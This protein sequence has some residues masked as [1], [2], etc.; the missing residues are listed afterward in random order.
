MSGPSERVKQQLSR[1]LAKEL[2]VV[3]STGVAPREQIEAHLAEHLEHQIKLEK[4]GLLFAA[5]PTTN[6]DGSRGPGLIIIRAKS[7]AD[8]RA[9]AMSDPMHKTGMRAFSIMKWSMNE[10]S[11]SVRVNYSDQSVQID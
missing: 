10:G 1:M 5:G 4:S 2:Y 8:A 9:I 3:Q 11:Y 6:E 7:F